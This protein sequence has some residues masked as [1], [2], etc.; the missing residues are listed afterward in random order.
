MHLLLFT[1]YFPPEV[2]A[3]QTRLDAMTRRTVSAGHRVTVVTAMPSYPTARVLVGYRRRLFMRE[4][5]GGRQ[6]VRTWAFPSLGAGYRRMLSYASFAVA[7][8][9]G[10]LSTRR[11]DIVVIE[12]PPLTNAIPAV[13]WARARRVPVVF[14]VADLWP[15]AAVAMGGLR[16]GKLLDVLFALERWAYRNASLVTT[17]TEGVVGRL[18]R[19]KHV[20]PAKILLVPNGVDTEMFAPDQADRSVLKQ[21]ALSDHP[22]VIYAGTMSLAHGIDGLI[23]AFIELANDPTSP[24]LVLVGS[25]SERERVEARVLAAGV[26]NI[27]LR[28]PI[29]PVELA[30]LLPLATAGV[31]TM[32]EIPLNRSTRPAKLFPLMSAG[33]PVIHAGAGEGGGCVLDAGAGY[34]VPNNSGDIRDAVLALA[35][36]PEVAQAMGSQG[37]E[38]VLAR[39]SWDG[40]VNDWLDRLSH[41]A[42]RRTS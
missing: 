41:I 2:G 5:I 40:I 35:S 18:V 13:I 12:S 21:L 32:A 36:D 14:N 37:R 33:I 27:H 3:P 7:G 17:V 6:I 19:D 9:I 8:G 22:F 29:P 31:V 26:S 30:K 4:S 20:D 1:Q 39:W 15:D 23:D 16:S 42:P 24:H 34:A 28:D 25:G 10:L 11:P 38:Y